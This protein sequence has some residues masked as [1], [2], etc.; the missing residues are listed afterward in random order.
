MAS[1][2]DDWRKNLVAPKRDTRQ[3]TEDVIG[4]RGT[5]FEDYFLTREILMGLFEA[6]F[7]HPSPIQEES[8]PMI[9]A[10]RDMLARAKNGT[11]KTA[12]FII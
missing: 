12:S 5:S 1:A 6:G 11:G 9:L 3:Q 7:E 4:K 2:E 10:G 8:I